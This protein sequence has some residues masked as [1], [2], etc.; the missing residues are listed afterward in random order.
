MFLKLKNITTV[1][2]FICT[3]LIDCHATEQTSEQTAPST[4]YVFIATDARTTLHELPDGDLSEEELNAFAD[5]LAIDSNPTV[6][7]AA[8][9]YYAPVYNASM[10]YAPVFDIQ[11]TTGPSYHRNPFDDHS[12][13]TSTYI[14]PTVYEH[15]AA[16]EYRTSAYTPYTAVP[17]Y[18]AYTAAP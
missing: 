2:G 10:Y 17:A 5:N 8:P 3:A 14:D 6:T 13:S 7:S 4:R 9:A 18:T 16:P 1:C 11:R 12:I 15:T